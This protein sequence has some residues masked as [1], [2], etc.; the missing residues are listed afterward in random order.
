MIGWT[1]VRTEGDAALTIVL[2]AVTLYALLI[3]YTGLVGL[4]GFSKEPWCSGR[5]SG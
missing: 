1:W 3:F 4:H 2:S 5:S